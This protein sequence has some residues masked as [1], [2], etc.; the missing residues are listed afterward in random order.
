MRFLKQNE[1]L[2]SASFGDF[3]FALWRIILFILAWLQAVA[4]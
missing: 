4:V 2:Q 3:R 1:S